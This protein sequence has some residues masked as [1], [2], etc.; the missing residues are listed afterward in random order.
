MKHINTLILLLSALMLI[1]PASYAH[2]YQ[3]HNGI[4]INFGTHHN[5]ISLKYK[6]PRKHAYSNKKYDYGH[7]PYYRHKAKT[8]SHS[9]K[10]KYQHYDRYSKHKKAKQRYSQKDYHRPYRKHTKSC[11]PVSKTVEGRR[12]YR[13]EIGGTMCYDRK[14]YAYIVP[15]SRYR[16]R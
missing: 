6:T 14:G 13:K 2:D 3:R 7:K 12:G 16:I 15:G 11:H 10:P 8:A 1:S 5:G 9:Y 4:S